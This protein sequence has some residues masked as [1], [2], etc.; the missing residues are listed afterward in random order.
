MFVTNQ[1]ELLAQL[2][3]SEEKLKTAK[4]DTTR[5]LDHL[6]PE[7]LTKETKIKGKDKKN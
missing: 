2:N 3:V 6:K 5:F 7:E 1:T 4:E